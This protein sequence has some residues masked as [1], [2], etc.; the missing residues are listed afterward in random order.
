MGDHGRL[1]DWMLVVWLFRRRRAC[2]WARP[3]SPP[4]PAEPMHR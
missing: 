1:T 2:C 4:L 3:S